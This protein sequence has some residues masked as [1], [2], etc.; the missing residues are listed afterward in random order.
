MKNKIYSCLVVFFCLFLM[1][2]SKDGSSDSK[3]IAGNST[4]GSLA[5]FTIV[6]NYLYTI[7]HQNLKSFNINNPANPIL[8]SEITIGQ[9]IETIYSFKN[10]LFIGSSTNMYVYSLAN[11][12]KPSVA[13]QLAYWVRGKDPVVANDTVAFSTVRNV[14]GMGGVL[15]I[16]NIKNINSAQLTGSI[17]MQSPYGLGLSDSAL[18]IC[19]HINGLK[20]YALSTK[21]GSIP[22]YKKTITNSEIFYD[23]IPFNN[24]LYAYIAGGNC[25]FDI[26]DKMNPVLLSKTKN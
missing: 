10:N 12:G 8:E 26:S 22:T 15:N 19:E 25:I 18:Y 21:T 9:E 2:C 14:S 20:V 7:N 11:P 1:N 24:L 3:S 17:T 13:T 23:V 5:R 4:G 6:G 16:I